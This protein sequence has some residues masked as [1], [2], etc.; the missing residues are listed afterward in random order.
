MAQWLAVAD[1]ETVR[2]F[3]AHDSLIRFTCDL[4]PGL[5]SSLGSAGRPDL[6]G[7]LTRS[8]T[9]AFKPFPTSAPR[10]RCS[11]RR[12]SQQSSQDPAPAECGVRVVGW[13][14]L[15]DAEGSFPGFSALQSCRGLVSEVG[16]FGVVFLGLG[17]CFFL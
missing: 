7:S 12:L 1:A 8:I 14:L 16:L 4:C 11:L 15:A 2:R 9:Q 17:D 3:Q 13:D 6:P 5:V 10:R